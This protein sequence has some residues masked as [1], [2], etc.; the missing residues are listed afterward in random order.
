M[1]LSISSDPRGCPWFLHSFPR[2]VHGKGVLETDGLSL[3]LSIRPYLLRRKLKSEELKYPIHTASGA[4][5]EPRGG[6]ALE[7]PSHPCQGS[8]WIQIIGKPDQAS[9]AKARRKW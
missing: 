1:F 7:M 9:N 5:P 2:H 6:R 4:G 8:L 3:S